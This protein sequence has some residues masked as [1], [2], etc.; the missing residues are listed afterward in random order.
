MG[1]GFFHTMGI[2]DLA[3]RDFNANDVAAAPKVGIL[4]LRAWHRLGIS[5]QNPDRQASSSRI[6]I[7]WEGKPVGDLD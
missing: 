7:R 1:A 2:P 6:S 3:G 5:G 4:K